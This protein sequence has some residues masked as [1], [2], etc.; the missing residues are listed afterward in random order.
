MAQGPQ[1]RGRRWAQDRHVG[2]GG[3]WGD[4]PVFDTITKC[5]KAD[6]DRRDR[7]STLFDREMVPVGEGE[8]TY[9]GIV[10]VVQNNLFLIQPSTISVMKPLR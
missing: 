7:I 6:L 8:T 5:L 4:L 9:S 1:P 3:R 2:K 10:R